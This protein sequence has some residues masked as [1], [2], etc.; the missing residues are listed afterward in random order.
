[1]ELREARKVVTMPSLSAL[2]K[3]LETITTG[4]EPTTYD[5]RRPIL[6][7]LV[8][9]RMEYCGR[10]AY[11]SKARFRSMIPRLSVSRWGELLS[12]CSRRLAILPAISHSF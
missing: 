6:E 1:M 10:K 12:G 11:R 5:E 4:A 9:L 2:E 7:G 8:D 3:R